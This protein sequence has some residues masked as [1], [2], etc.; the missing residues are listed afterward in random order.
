M[1][2]RITKPALV[3][4]NLVLRTATGEASIGQLRPLSQGHYLKTS[5]V[6]LLAMQLAH[7]GPLG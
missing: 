1:G 4:D 3:A 5:M 7:L 2:S 6:P